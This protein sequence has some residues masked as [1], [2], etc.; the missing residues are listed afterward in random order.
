MVHLVYH[1]HN[2][3]QAF[4]S[5]SIS[6]RRVKC[7]TSTFMCL[8]S[9]CQQGIPLPSEYLCTYSRRR[10]GPVKT[11]RSGLGPGVVDQQS[12]V[13]LAIIDF[14]RSGWHFKIPK[15]RAAQFDAKFKKEEDCPGN[16]AVLYQWASVTIELKCSQKRNDELSRGSSKYKRFCMLDQVQQHSTEHDG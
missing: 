2:I 11:K 5:S 14:L 4:P 16:S 8:L 15:Q 7:S 6:L 3:H 1:K 9:E 10:K 12:T 13:P